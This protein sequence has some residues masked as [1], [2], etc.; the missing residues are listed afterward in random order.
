MRQLLL[1]C[2]AF[3]CL[4]ALLALAALALLPLSPSATSQTTSTYEGD[5]TLPVGVFVS[6]AVEGNPLPAAVACPDGSELHS[7]DAYWEFEQW[8][9]SGI[10][11]PD[12]HYSGAPAGTWNGLYLAERLVNSSYGGSHSRLV[13]VVTGTPLRAG[14]ARVTFTRFCFSTGGGLRQIRAEGGG[15]V[16]I[17]ASGDDYRHPDGHSHHVGHSHPVVPPTPSW[18]D[19]HAEYAN[20]C[21]N[22]GGWYDTAWSRGATPRSDPHGHCCIPAEADSNYRTAQQCQNSKLPPATPSPSGGSGTESSADE[23][24]DE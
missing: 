10:W 6:D 12:G 2:S 21:R 18:A 4:P 13:V 15:Q 1:R 9:A 14:L 8:P 16:I 22:I 19:T 24:D 17:A 5:I 11:V 3:V 7:Y 23:D 20:S